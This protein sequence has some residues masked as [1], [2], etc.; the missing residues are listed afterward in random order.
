MSHPHPSRRAAGGTRPGPRTDASRTRQDL[1]RQLE[2][3]DAEANTY[4]V[5]LA[6]LLH[7]LDGV[8]IVTMAEAQEIPKDSVVWTE[9]INDE[10]DV[11]I[12]LAPP[13]EEKPWVDGS[14]T[15]EEES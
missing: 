11:R 15:M 3:R 1:I 4:F 12:W 13:A 9:Q 7:R 6:Q 14:A 10:G 8:T 2:R 5:L